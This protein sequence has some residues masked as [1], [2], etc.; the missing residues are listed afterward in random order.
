MT[1]VLFAQVGLR[2]PA[3]QAQRALVNH[4]LVDAPV[5]RARL[6][7]AFDHQIVGQNERLG[8]GRLLD[9]DAIEL[10][11]TGAGVHE[12]YH[13]LAHELHEAQA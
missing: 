12:R 1:S 9:L 7:R 10:E 8:V 11:E 5:Q 4:R 3:R 6:E 13:A 2:E